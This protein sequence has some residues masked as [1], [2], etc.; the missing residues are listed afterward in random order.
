MRVHLG[1]LYEMARHRFWQCQLISRKNFDCPDSSAKNYDEKKKDFLFRKKKTKREKWRETS[2]TEQKQKSKAKLFGIK[3]P[4]GVSESKYKRMK[5]KKN[6]SHAIQVPE[7]VV[8]R[9]IHFFQLYCFFGVFN[10]LWTENEK[11][12]VLNKIEDENE[13]RVKHTHTQNS[14]KNASLS[15]QRALILINKKYGSYSQTL[16]NE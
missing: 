1:W 12:D 11:E 5:W 10:C 2:R 16:D 14:K 15:G 7:L 8:R 3:Y 9:F 13:R 4:A 6:A